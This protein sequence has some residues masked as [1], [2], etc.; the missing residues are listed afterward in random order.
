MAG[1]GATCTADVSLL[2]H[3][4]KALPPSASVQLSTRGAVHCAAGQGPAPGVRSK[5]TLL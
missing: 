1:G 2:Q 4:L 5:G 3:V